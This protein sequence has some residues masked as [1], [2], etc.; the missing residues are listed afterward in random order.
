LNREHP[1]VRAEADLYVSHLGSVIDESEPVVRSLIAAHEG[2]TGEVLVEHPR[3]A[4]MDSSVLNS[5][6]I[7]TVVYGPSGR[8]NRPQ[9]ADAG[10]SPS[11]GEHTY[12]PDVLTHART[13]GAVIGDLCI[14]TAE[15]VGAQTVSSFGATRR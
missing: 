15:E 14:R 11:E 9:A 10:W 13:I 3:G 7:P 1:A 5:H 12:L 8:V 4:Y 6:G 2:V